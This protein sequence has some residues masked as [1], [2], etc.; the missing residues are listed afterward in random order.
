MKDG[1]L[2]VAVSTPETKVANVKYNTQLVIDIARRAAMEGVKV[3]ALPELVL[4]T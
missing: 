1:F 2:K 3:L 4:S